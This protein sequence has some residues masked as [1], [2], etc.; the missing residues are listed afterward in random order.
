[1]RSPFYGPVYRY[2]FRTAINYVDNKS[3]SKA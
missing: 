1:M 2:A 3:E